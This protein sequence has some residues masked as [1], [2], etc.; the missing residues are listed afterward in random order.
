[1]HEAAMLFVSRLSAH[2]EL[3]GIL[4]GRQPTRHRVNFQD[5]LTLFD[6]F[7]SIESSVHV[8]S[9]FH[10]SWIMANSATLFIRQ[11]SESGR[12][13][14][15]RRPRR[16]RQHTGKGRDEYASGPILHFKLWR[17]M[18]LPRQVRPRDIPWRL[19]H[20]PSF[21]FFLIPYPYSAGAGSPGPSTQ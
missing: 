19:L 17:T 21:T 12:N 9:F 7:Q 20:Y 14:V 1:M 4:K 2:S 18:A 15:N 13:S 16:R 8:S 3:Y 10:A 11:L 6:V 5:G